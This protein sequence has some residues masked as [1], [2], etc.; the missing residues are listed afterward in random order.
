M[1][2]T[3][4]PGCITG[5]PLAM[6]VRELGG[7]ETRDGRRIKRGL[8]YRGSTLAGLD[9]RQRAIIDGLGIRF[10]FDLRAAGEASKHLEYIPEGATYRRVAG[11]YEPNG[12]EMDFSPDAIARIEEESG[13][14][15]IMHALYLSMVHSNPALHALVEHLMAH[16][17][18]LYFHCSAG[19]DRTGI[20]AAL[21][22][23]IL[24]VDDDAIVE[25]FLLT[26]VFRAEIIDNPPA[27]LPEHMESVEMW[28][29]A[30]GV[31]AES[32]RAVLAAMGDES[33]AR[34]RY[35]QQEFGL[36]ASDLDSLRAFYLE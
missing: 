31:Q 29:H 18:P 5:L 35:L 6:N 4:Q 32:L 27:V 7:I 22:L 15:D 8:L 2:A 33:E 36:E 30:N 11:M 23:S 25:N 20:S 21:I 3:N 10:V 26:N 17:A 19:K 24:G 28:R 16:D 13:S 1:D 34:E 12:A 14:D 9:D